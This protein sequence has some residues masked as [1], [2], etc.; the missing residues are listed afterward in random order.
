MDRTILRQIV[1]ELVESNTNEPLEHFDDDTDLRT[2]LGLDSVDLITLAMEIQDHFKVMI[3]PGD[4][5][6]LHTVGNLL[7]FLH[8]RVSQG[9]QAA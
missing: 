5:E 9:K 4:F 6:Q 8:V 1:R 7:D 3:A 2:G